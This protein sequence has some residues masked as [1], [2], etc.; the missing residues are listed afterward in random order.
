MLND[1]LL[2]RGKLHWI[3][4]IGC[5]KLTKRLIDYYQLFL[6]VLFLFPAWTF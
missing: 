2:K 6:N 4:L 5:F 1:V 3:I